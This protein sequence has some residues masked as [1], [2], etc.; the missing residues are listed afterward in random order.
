MSTHLAQHTAARRLAPRRG[1]FL[2]VAV[3]A[4]RAIGRGLVIV[5]L[6]LLPLRLAVYLANQV[7]I[8]AGYVSSTLFLVGIMLIEVNF[9]P[10]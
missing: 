4:A 10:L 1:A 9:V 5:S 8:L 7:L 6:L 2:A 3:H